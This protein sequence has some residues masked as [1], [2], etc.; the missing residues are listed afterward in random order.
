MKV[1]VSELSKAIVQSLEEYTNEVQEEIKDEEEK[2]AKDGVQQLKSTSPKRKGK[3]GRGWKL[4]KEKDGTTVHNR[5]YQLTH[6]LEHGHAKVNGG[7]VEGIPHIAPVEEMM[8][9]Q[10]ERA[11]EKA[12]KR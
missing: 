3:Y 9:T 10:Y 11:V 1:N 12:V 7:R 4:T 2:I 8:I 6:L 5:V